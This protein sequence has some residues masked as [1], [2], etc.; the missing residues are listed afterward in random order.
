M[1]ILII[2]VLVAIGLIYLGTRSGPDHY[3]ARDISC[4]QVCDINNPG[5]MTACSSS[6][7]AESKAA[8]KIYYACVK[9]CR[10]KQK[11]E[12]KRPGWGLPINPE[13]GGGSR[14]S[15]IF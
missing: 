9:D 14:Y 1:C 8:C 10:D 6:E 5:A 7:G 2:L 13:Q 4:S 11:E 15:H 12:I 3:Q